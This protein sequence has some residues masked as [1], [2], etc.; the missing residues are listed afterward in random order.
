M[1]QHFVKSII[2]GGAVG[3]ALGVPVEGMERQELAM[4]PI[5]TM[6]GGGRY[7]QEK[8]TWS[9]DTSMTLASLESLTYGL[10][11]NDVME[12]FKNWYVNGDYT[13]RG[14]TF[15]VGMTTKTAIENYLH[16]IPPL[17]CGIKDV[18]AN[19]NGALMRMAPYV[20]YLNL[21][22]YHLDE[23][24]YTGFSVIHKASAL[25]H[26]H[27]RSFVG[28]DIYA[29]VLTALL[30][31]SQQPKERVVQR[32]IDAVLYALDESMFSNEIK[33]EVSTYEHLVDIRALMES[34]EREIASSGYIVHTLEAALYCFLNT[35]SYK[36]CVLK[37]VNL[38]DDTDTT[39]A[40]AGSLAGAYYGFEAIPKTWLET[41]ARFEWINSLCVSFADRNT[42]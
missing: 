16:R 24:D 6:T 4:H 10:D 2:F 33:A 18:Y 35:S 37:A 19:G 3:D 36:E 27:P 13:P 8:G 7:H 25:T 41:L 30:K 20:L 38:G 23:F 1:S 21:H 32:A 15:G 9:D 14:E 39:A 28:C 12:R 5:K 17:Q 42:K 29:K 11:F 34:P 40:V 26:R 22:N 31:P